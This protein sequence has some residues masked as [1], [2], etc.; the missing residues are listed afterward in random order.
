MGL[1]DTQK[2]ISPAEL[3]AGLRRLMLDAAFA[4][5]VGTLNSG[6]V[7]IAYALWLGASPAVIGLLAAIPFLTQLLQAPTVLLLEKVRSRRLV[8]VAGVFDE[9]PHIAVRAIAAA[10]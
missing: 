7:L 9:Q 2:Q 3:D 8:S 5:I 4:T 6:V 10:V 1:A